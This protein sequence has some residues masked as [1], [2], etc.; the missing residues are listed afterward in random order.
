LGGV[1]ESL[2]N[3]LE[4]VA[5]GRARGQMRGSAHP[6][7]G[8]RTTPL[9]PTQRCARDQRVRRKSRHRAVARCVLLCGLW[10][11]RWLS[12]AC[13]P[14]SATNG[15]E[16]RYDVYDAASNCCIF[17]TDAAREVR[18]RVQIRRVPP[19]GMTKQSR[20][21]SVWAHGR[22]LRTRRALR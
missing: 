20:L 15:A 4:R 2:G 5:A 21:L 1:M 9:P 11:W 13:A 14:N 6:I 19:V 22:R 7:G 12:A 8:R 18:S 17:G 10:A 16:K 3:A